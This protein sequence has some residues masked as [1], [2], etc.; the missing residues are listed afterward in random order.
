MN[1]LHPVPYVVPEVDYCVCG[2]ALPDGPYIAQQT[3]EMDLIYISSSNP[4]A[5]MRC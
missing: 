4:A 3:S 2:K 1:P 5:A